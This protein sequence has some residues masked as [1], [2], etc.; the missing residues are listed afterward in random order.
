MT[1]TYQRFKQ[2]E[3]IQRLTDRM[4]NNSAFWNDDEK[5]F[6]LNEAMAVWQ[7]MVGEWTS[8]VGVTITPELLDNYLDIPKQV[9]S[10]QRVSYN[11]IPLTLVSLWDLD[12]L[13]SSGWEGSGT[14]PLRWAPIGLNKVVLQP[15]PSLGGR[16][17]FAGISEVP[18]PLNGGDWVNFGDDLLTAF[19]K[20]EHHYLTFK[21]GGQELQA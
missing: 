10:L 7:M 2:S 18:F 11:S 15:R 12:N 4:G 13:F 5:G 9:V 20:Y 17:N 3:V 8:E 16:I 21:E 6:S 19:L 1:N 14:T